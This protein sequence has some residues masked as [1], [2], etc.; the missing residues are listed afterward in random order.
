MFSRKFP[1][2]NLKGIF[3]F[4]FPWSLSVPTW[5]KLCNKKKKIVQRVS[6]KVSF[7]RWQAP[8]LLIMVSFKVKLKIYLQFMVNKMQFLSG[9][10]HQLYFLHWI[11]LAFWFLTRR[12]QI[13]ERNQNYKTFSQIPSKYWSSIRIN[14]EKYKDGLLFYFSDGT[15]KSYL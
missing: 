6:L 15:E 2:I 14:I 12:W 8:H 1:L 4:F 5:S 7:V 13:Y 10:I 9:F 11:Q 3:F